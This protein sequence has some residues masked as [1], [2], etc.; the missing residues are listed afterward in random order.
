MKIGVQLP[1]FGVD[2]SATAA[3][4]ARH[5]EGL[6]LESVWTGDHL[7]P[8][9]P[10]LDSTLVQATVAAGTSRIKLGFGVMIPALRGAAWAAKQIATLQHL[11]GDRL[12]VGIGSGGDPHG[13]AAWRA[14]GVPYRERGKRTDA[15]LAV[16]P[17]LV[18]GREAAIDGEVVRLS[19]PATVPPLLIGGSGPVAWRR[20]QR[21]GAGWYPAFVPPSVVADGI[22]QL[23][24][25]GIEAPVTVGVSVG[26]GP[27]EQSIVD[28][29]VRGLADYGM[30]EEQ[31]RK[32]LVTGS[33]A[34]AAE[35]LAAFAEAGAERVVAMPFPADRFQQRELL[36]EAAKQLGA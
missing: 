17:D 30:G 1:S 16:L 28:D 18:A 6:G 34:Q 25:L 21:L 14:V 12:I 3:E 8:A 23:R 32:A 29:R 13:D 24:E 5:A 10:Y 20:I 35:Q 2:P 36:A 26:L 22:R 19:P 11:S 9:L 33:P 7:I 31:A 15:V 4:H 27:L